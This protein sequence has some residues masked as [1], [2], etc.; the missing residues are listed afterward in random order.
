LIIDLLLVLGSTENPVNK[1]SRVILGLVFGLE[2]AGS[3]A[4]ERWRRADLNEALELV[5]L[6]ERPARGV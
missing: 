6:E 1:S 5:L 2:G 4:R 3:H